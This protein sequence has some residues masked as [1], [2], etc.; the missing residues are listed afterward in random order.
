MVKNPFGGS[1]KAGEYSV[2]WDG[3][4]GKGHLVPN[5]I[6]FYRLDAPGFMAAKKAVVTR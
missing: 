2:T 4:D 5:G 6:Y 3:R 1:K